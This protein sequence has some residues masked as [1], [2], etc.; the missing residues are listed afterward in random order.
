[1][2]GEEICLCGR[3][4][5][6]DIKEEWG[7]WCVDERLRLCDAR[8]EGPF[9]GFAE[10]NGGGT[11]GIVET[12]YAI[13]DEGGGEREGG[14]DFEARVVRYR[15]KMSRE[16]GENLSQCLVVKNIETEWTWRG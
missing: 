14:V 8:T 15:G 4:L 9:E 3:V 6:D 11:W 2:Q 16:E 7:V 1:M 5:E 12:G 10:G 13:A